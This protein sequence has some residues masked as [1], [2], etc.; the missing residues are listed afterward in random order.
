[1]R[2][3]RIANITVD[4]AKHVERY[5]SVLSILTLGLAMVKLHVW[6]LLAKGIRARHVIKQC[7]GADLAKLAELV[8]EGALRPIVER[9]LPLAEIAEAHRASESHRTRGKIVLSVGAR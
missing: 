6:P 4:V 3:G 7:R 1:R 8:D 9:V 5:G 2:G